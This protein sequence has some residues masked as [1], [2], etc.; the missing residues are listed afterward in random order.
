MYFALYSFHLRLPPHLLLQP[1]HAGEALRPL[2]HSARH[3]Q[4]TVVSS[5]REGQGRRCLQGERARRDHVSTSIDWTVKRMGFGLASWPKPQARSR[6]AQGR[7]V[8]E[9]CGPGRLTPVLPSLRSHG[10]GGRAHRGGRAEKRRRSSSTRRA[11][12]SAALV[13]RQRSNSHS[14]MAL[15]CSTLHRDCSSIVQQAKVS[16]TQRA[17]SVTCGC[18]THALTLTRL[19]HPRSFGAPSRPRTPRP[20]G[21]ATFDVVVRPTL[22]SSLTCSSSTSSG[23]ATAD[24]VAVAVAAP[25]GGDVDRRCGDTDVRGLG[26]S[27]HG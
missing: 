24:T 21:H 10:E 27:S 17:R 16:V 2:G 13:M 9:T 22:S 5:R 23:S 26:L 7:R 14:L 20:K 3:S 6:R 12:A 19:T 25:R 8:S 4:R 18:R 11:S 1:M 15:V